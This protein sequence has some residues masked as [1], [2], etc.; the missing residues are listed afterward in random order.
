MYATKIINGVPAI[1][2]D[3]RSV[4]SVCDLD[5]DF[6]NWV[7]AL[8]NQLGH[9]PELLREHNPEWSKAMDVAFRKR[10]QHA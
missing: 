2:R 7:C 6:A 4:L 3:G 5:W 9:M 10:V 8:L 1:Q